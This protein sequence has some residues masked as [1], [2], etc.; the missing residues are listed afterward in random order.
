MT[1]EP[2]KMP[3][4]VSSEGLGT[5]LLAERFDNCLAD[6]WMAFQPIVSAKEGSIFGF[7]ALLRSREPSLPHP[8]AVLEAGERLGRLYEIGRTTRE[9]AFQEIPED[10]SFTLF[11]NLHP[12][13]LSDEALIESVARRPELAPRLVLEVTE[14]AALTDIADAKARLAELRALG[15][16]IAIDDL[17]AGYS[18]LSSLVE[19]EPDIVKLDMVMVRNLHQSR[20]KQRLVR[21][22]VEICHELEIGVVAEGVEV[23]EERQALVESGCDFLQ[24]YLLGKP[25]AGFGF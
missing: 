8:G 19:L 3:S 22:L 11:L 10:S 2:F 18:G 15:C 17:G 4:S 12:L 21:S 25:R 7:E 16:R 24:G 14:R 5:N 6:L 20:L 13:D 9:R 23:E 1:D